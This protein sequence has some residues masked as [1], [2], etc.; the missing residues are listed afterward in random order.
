[1]SMTIGFFE[2]EKWTQ[3]QPLTWTRPVFAL[4]CGIDRLFE[5][6]LRAYGQAEAAYWTRPLVAAVWQEAVPGQPVNNAA[7]RGGLWLNG[8]LMSGA[9]LAATIP[10]KGPDCLFLVNGEVAAVRLATKCFGDLVN[11]QGL[12]DPQRCLNMPKKT[13]D[14]SLAEYPWDLIDALHI[15]IAAD[16]SARSTKA[17]EALPQGVYHSGTH[18]VY[19]EAG[20][21]IAPGTVLNTAEGPIWL[22]RDVQVDALS[23]LEGPLAVGHG[24]RIKTGAKIYGHTALGPVCKVGGEVEGCIVQGFSNK[25]HDGFLGHAFLGEW[26]NLGANTNNS[27]LKNNYGGIRIRIGGKTVQT[28]RQL[29]GLIMGDHA[30]SAI[31][32]R[33]N[34]ATVVGAFANVFSSDFPPKTVPNFAWLGR[35]LMT[36]RAPEAMDM[37]RRMMRRRQIELTPAYE[38]MVSALYAMTVGRGEAVQ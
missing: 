6:G 32:T 10:V 13:V 27:D 12:F 28:G 4:R 14:L 9:E 24:S 37:A 38:D 33:F 1:M 5:K 31:S 36:T 11:E 18:P 7:C 23:Y 17:F 35:R 21:L 3:F 26:I 25:Q 15:E 2:D 16:I 22:G 20:V 8:R 19:V 29:L 30:K 34:T